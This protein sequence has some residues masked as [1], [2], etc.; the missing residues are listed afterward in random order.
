MVERLWK[1]RPFGGGGVADTVVREDGEE[2]AAGDEAIGREDF[3]DVFGKECERAHGSQLS[4]EF[5]LRLL[6][7]NR[8]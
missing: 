3:G 6:S 8:L 7:H 1:R 4:G 5:A 2:A